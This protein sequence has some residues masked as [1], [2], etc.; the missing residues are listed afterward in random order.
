MLIDQ[1]ILRNE[2]IWYV[3]KAQPL[4][5]TKAMCLPEIFDFR[6]FSIAESQKFLT[7][8]NHPKL[9]RL[10]FNFNFHKNKSKI[11]PKFR[12]QLE[13]VKNIPEFLKIDSLCQKF[14][15]IF[16]IFDIYIWNTPQNGFKID[17]KWSKITKIIPEF[18]TSY[19][20]WRTFDF[21]QTV[22]NVPNYSCFVYR[23]SRYIFPKLLKIP[24]LL[25]K[26]MALAASILRSFGKFC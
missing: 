2:C 10:Y 5:Y 7:V 16:D 12:N 25:P 18:S 1:F 13:N 22:E 15:Y 26:R 20:K 23:L 17:Q 3:L 14:R 19:Q 6:Q 9:S 11:L 4:M 21:W 8:K 24:K